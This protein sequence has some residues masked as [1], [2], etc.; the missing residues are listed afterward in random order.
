MKPC[1]IGISLAI[2]C[3]FAHNALAQ[4][5][6]NTAA[7]VAANVAR[8]AFNT[9]TEGPKADGRVIKDENPV[10]VIKDVANDRIEILIKPHEVVAGTDQKI[11]NHVKSV[12]PKKLG[13]TVEISR[14]PEKLSKEA[15][16]VLSKTAQDVLETGKV[17]NV[18]GMP[19]A[20]GARQAVELYQDRA[21]P[22]PADIRF[23]LTGVFSKEILDRAQFVIDDNV[24]S[25]GIIN[26]FQEAFADNHAVTADNIIVFAKPPSSKG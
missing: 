18:I 3:A 19:L 5:D 11:E 17:G 7:N 1:S 9:V 16:I 20:I 2:S 14:L 10:K 26:K 15:P 6:L 12:L 22:I 24:G 25:H 21:K 13:R 23:Y 4:M 8:A